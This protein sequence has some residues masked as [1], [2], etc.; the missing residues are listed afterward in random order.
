M[1]IE[2]IFG[3]NKGLRIAGGPMA[4]LSVNVALDK[5]VRPNTNCSPDRR[6]SPSSKP[7]KG[8]KGF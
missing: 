3:S 6:K 7:K 1:E 4:G 8:S 5:K 2:I